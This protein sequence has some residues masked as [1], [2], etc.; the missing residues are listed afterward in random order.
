[1]NQLLSLSLSLLVYVVRIQ[2]HARMYIGM[3]SGRCHWAFARD[4]AKREP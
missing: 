1:M 4:V 2:K 3:S